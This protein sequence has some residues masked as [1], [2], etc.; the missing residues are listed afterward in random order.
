MH[1][2][3]YVHG[4]LQSTWNFTHLATA[5]RCKECTPN[6]P[7]EGHLV[8]SSRYAYC[9]VSGGRYV[10]GE[11]RALVYICGMHMLFP[12]I[13]CSAFLRANCLLWYVIVCYESFHWGFCSKLT[14]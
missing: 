10:S 8:Y 3:M 5:S 4:I 2:C 1:I 11:T 7:T 9:M 13:P 14:S 6:V 12:V